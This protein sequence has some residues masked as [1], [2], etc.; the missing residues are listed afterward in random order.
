MAAIVGMQY[1]TESAHG[2]YTWRCKIGSFCIIKAL[3]LFFTKLWS[4]I[5]KIN[6]CLKQNNYLFY[7]LSPQFESSFYCGMSRPKRKSTQPAIIDKLKRVKVDSFNRNAQNVCFYFLKFSQL[8][9]VEGNSIIESDN[10][11]HAQTF[12]LPAN[13]RFS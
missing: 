11:K 3:E 12:G 4:L 2:L 8:A 7:P 1:V 9:S 10:V 13:M 5:L 6:L